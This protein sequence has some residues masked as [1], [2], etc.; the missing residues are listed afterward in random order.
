[1]SIIKINK[2]PI[3]AL[4]ICSFLLC[5]CG[6]E[7]PAAPILTP[8]PVP[9]ETEAQE[10]N[11]KTRD[12]TLK[13]VQLSVSGSAQSGSLYY[14][15]TGTGPAEAT[16][17]YTS[18]NTAFY[19]AGS[20]SSVYMDSEV[21]MFKTGEWKQQGE[22]FKNIWEYVQ[23]EDSQLLEDSSINNISCFHIATTTEDAVPWIYGLL[24]SA[25][26]DG[27]ANGEISLDYY[28]NKDN[29]NIMQTDLS[30]PFLASLRGKEANGQLTA[31]LT[32]DEWPEAP[33]INRP[34]TEE[35]SSEDLGSISDNVYRSTVFGIQIA[36]KELLSFDPDKTEEIKQQYISS[37]SSYREEAYATGGDIILNVSAIDSGSTKE[38]I[39]NKYL[40]DSKATNVQESGS[41]QVG[42]VEFATAAA[43]INDTKTKTYCGKSGNTAMVI[44]LYYKDD[45]TVSSFE[46]SFYGINDDPY[47][48]E[49]EWS[50]LGGR[51][52]IK[53]VNGYSLAQENCGDLFACMKKNND[54]VNVFAL[55]STTVENEIGKISSEGGEVTGQDSVDIG[56][57]QS[58]T[59]VTA[60]YTD[61]SYEYWTY[62]GF[63][64][65]GN[66]VI[67]YYA[68]STSAKKNYTSIYTA[69]AQ[70]TSVAQ[71]EQPQSETVQ[72]GSGE[73]TQQETAM[74]Q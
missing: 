8:T 1:M 39:L 60:H 72:D 23:N 28:I 20:A 21:S 50:L 9:K 36:G 12:T 2:I 65:V 63:L 69:L 56:N 44:T 43:T 52:K 66:D 22:D 15:I 17:S 29:G 55:E 42:A 32:A 7:E 26:Y 18:T 73:Q 61:P 49:E 46:S 59:Y 31:R 14:Q 6:K 47:W 67:E 62:T 30:M 74:Q 57:G 68:V 71:T 24:Y 33:Q 3:S 38:E 37:N 27:I 25:G 64:P 53:T 13:D 70:N 58:M 5:G 35:K 41:F 48:A 10:T 19:G 16:L 11:Y 54:E 40:S 34:V 51:Y 45:N 4:L